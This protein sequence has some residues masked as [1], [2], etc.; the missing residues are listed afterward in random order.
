[1]TVSI[2]CEVCGGLNPYCSWCEVESQSSIVYVPKAKVGLEVARRS[3]PTTVSDLA[4]Q[5]RSSQRAAKRALNY[6]V[7]QGQADYDT[8]TGRYE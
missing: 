7:H 6:L 5:E 1:M 3:L 8:R 4:V 2:G